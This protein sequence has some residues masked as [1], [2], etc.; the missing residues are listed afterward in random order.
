MR[1]PLAGKRAGVFLVD[2]RRA[3]LVRWA[4]LLGL[5]SQHARVSCRLLLQRL[6]IGA[7]H[8][9]VANAWVASLGRPRW[10]CPPSWQNS[11]A[12]PGTN[13]RWIDAQQLGDFAGL[14][15]LGGVLLAHYVDLQRSLASQLPDFNSSRCCRCFRG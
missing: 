4:I 2:D 1:E 3:E 6:H 9:P 15:F 13:G 14:E 7:P 5:S 8:A 11:I 12:D 10:T